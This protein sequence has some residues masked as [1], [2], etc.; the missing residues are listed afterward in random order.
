M[1][2]EAPTVIREVWASLALSL[3]RLLW[4][5]PMLGVVGLAAIP[6]VIAIVISAFPH[7]AGKIH[8]LAATHAIYE[9]FLRTLYIHFILFFV[10]N[11]LGFAVVRQDVEE[12]TLHYLL[13]QPAPRWAVLTGKYLAYVILAAGVCVASLWLTY[14]TMGVSLQGPRAVAV[15]LLK[16]GRFVIL[17]KES[18]VLVLEL[19]AYG[20]LAMLIGSM[21]KSGFQTILILAW[22]SAIPY[23]PSTLKLMTIMHYLQSLLPER[24]AENRRMFE[25][26]GEP[27]SAGVCLIVLVSL[28][29]LFFALTTLIFHFKECRYGDQ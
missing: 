21:F 4:S 26:L 6:L 5:T 16:D 27:A 25:L 10:A 9:M 22:E 3:R 20:G 2:R 11:L 18:L 17:A 23:L 7:G 19:M 15:D 12:Q 8:S 14:L 13:L 29:L 28:A 24:L 1:D